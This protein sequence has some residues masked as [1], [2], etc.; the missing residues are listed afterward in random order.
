M[1]WMIDL[2]VVLDVFQRREP[3]Y[4]ASAQILSKVLRREAT[5]CLPSH[6][7][8]TLHYVL[9]RNGN[10]ETAGEV[11]DWVL[12]HLEIVPQDLATFQRARQLPFADFE[13]AALA[14]AA[15][16]A[17]CQLIV[18]RNVKDFSGS[19]VPASTPAE[20]LAAESSP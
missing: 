1:R 2:N 10:A 11:L 3:F 18:T 19:P 8:T 6:L 13:D 4:E 17:G 14:S 20:L 7:L 12:E 15:E 9:Q 16:K 5:G